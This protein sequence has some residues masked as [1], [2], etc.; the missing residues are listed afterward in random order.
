MRFVT[1][2]SVSYSYGC[3]EKFSKSEYWEQEVKLCKETTR[4]ERSRMESELEDCA[5][6][7][8]LQGIL[9]L[10]GTVNPSNT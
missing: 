3:D 8:V 7:L 4:E 2:I 5:Y 10:C 1:Q 9:R 6:I